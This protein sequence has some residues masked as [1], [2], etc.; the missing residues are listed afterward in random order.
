MIADIPQPKQDCCIGKKKR[1][2]ELCT[3]YRFAFYIFGQQGSTQNLLKVASFV[4]NKK[5]S[6]YEAIRVDP[7]TTILFWNP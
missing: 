1:I 2:D 3:K 5:P 4:S 6:E 7:E